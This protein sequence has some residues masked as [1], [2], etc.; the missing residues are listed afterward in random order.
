MYKHFHRKKYYHQDSG[1]KSF[2]DLLLAILQGWVLLWML[3]ILPYVLSIYIFLVQNPIWLIP[4]WIIWL[5]VLGCVYLFL[6]QRKK[7]RFKAIQK[8]NELIDLSSRDFE[9]FCEQMFIEKWFSTV[10]WKWT[11]DWGV[12]ITAELWDK[13][14]I[15]QCKKY[16]EHNKVGSPIIQQLNWVVPESGD[17]IWRIIVTTSSF[18]VDAVSEAKKSWIELWDKNYLIKYLESKQDIQIQQTT[19][20]SIKCNLCWGNLVLRT[21]QEGAYKGN[22]FLWCENYPKCHFIKNI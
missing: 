5:F 6:D 2:R 1:I 13:K 21:A 19:E 18:T 3:C 9:F 20:S 12:D 7:N 17:Y 11:K 4:V 16:A 15:I 22:Q 14:F 10:I 8:L